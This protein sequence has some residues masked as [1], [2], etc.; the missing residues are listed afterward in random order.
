VPLSKLAKTGY[1][2]S[3]TATCGDFAYIFKHACEE[4]VAAIV[5]TSLGFSIESS[6][7]KDLDLAKLAKTIDALV[8]NQKDQRIQHNKIE[9]TEPIE[10]MSPAPKQAE[11]KK[12]T[13]RIPGLKRSALK[14][15][16]EESHK[17]CQT[18]GEKMFKNDRFEGCVC[19]KSLAKSITTKKTNGGYLLTV[20][21][22]NSEVICALIKDFK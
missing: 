20:S 1:G 17:D 2:F 15:S 4:Q 22:P 8:K 10:H 7:T 19:Y 13:V 21:G 3:G 14:L 16:E 18:C 9:E 6:K 11:T 5:L 12:R